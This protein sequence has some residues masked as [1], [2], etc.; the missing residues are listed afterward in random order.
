MVYMSGS[1]FLTLGIGDI[2]STDPT[3]R[4]FMIL[5]TATGYIF[6]G[7]IITYMPLLDQA[8][9]APQVGNLLIHSRAGRPPGAIKLLHRYASPDRMEIFRDNLCDRQSAG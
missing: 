7:L 4:T 5:E 3:A 6:L 2:T 9:R 1:T 8:Y